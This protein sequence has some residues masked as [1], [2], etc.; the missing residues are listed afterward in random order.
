MTESFSFPD[1]TVRVMQ[2]LQKTFGVKSNA[3]VISRA[4]SL[5]QI[6]ADKADPHNIVVVV[7]KDEPLKLN[8]A[9]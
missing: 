6:V 5:A 3:E 8:L 4:L 2:S 9:E 1:Q 7:G